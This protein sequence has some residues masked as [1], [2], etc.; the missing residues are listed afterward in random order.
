MMLRHKA[1]KG[2]RLYDGFLGRLGGT[3]EQIAI[4]ATNPLRSLKRRDSDES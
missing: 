1:G 3:Q 4:S 2:R